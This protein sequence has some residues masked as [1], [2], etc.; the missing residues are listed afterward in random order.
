[1]VLINKPHYK[2]VIFQHLND[3]NTY[4]K[5]T[6]NDWKCDNRVMEKIGELANK[7]DSL[8]TKTGMWYLTN[9]SLSTSNFYGLR[10]VPKSKQ[11]NEAIEPQNNENTEIHEPDD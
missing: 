9:I 11:I 5:K 2:K 4:Q 1:M 7:C 10:K 6:K 8:L 3:A